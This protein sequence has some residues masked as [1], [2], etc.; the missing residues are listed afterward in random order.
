M[1]VRRSMR[2]IETPAGTARARRAVPSGASS[3]PLLVL[4]HGAGGGVEAGDL[5]RVTAAALAAGFPVVLVDQPWRVAGRRIAPRPATLDAA[6]VSVLA[7]LRRTSPLVVGGRSAGARV[8]CRTAAEV[9]AAGILA[10]A[11]PLHPPG[12][13]ESTRAEELAATT[14]PTLVLQGDRDPFGTAV[15]VAARVPSVDVVEVPRGDHSLI[16]G[17]LD[18]AMPGVV[19]FLRRFAT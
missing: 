10:L 6:W 3:A 14:C 2:M 7:R 11:F 4:G 12:R 8:A 17:D 1:A 13:P 18:R 19:E 9:G 15:E 16:R 5:Q